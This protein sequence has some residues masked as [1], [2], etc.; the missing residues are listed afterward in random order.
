MRGAWF[1][2]VVVLSSGC[3]TGEKSAVVP[4]EGAI[5]GVELVRAPNAL[6][7]L[8]WQCNEL[9]L[10]VDCAPVGPRPP[11][12][13]L[14]IGFDI[15]I[16]VR[17]PNVTIQIPMI[18]A[19]TGLT[20]FDS[21]NLGSICVT[22]CDPE[23]ERCEAESNAEGAC[24]G[25]QGAPGPEDLA[26]TVPDLIELAIGQDDGTYENHQWRI[27]RA[28]DTTRVTLGY[29]L[30]PSVALP[31]AEVAFEAALDD[32]L[33]GGEPELLVPFSAEGALFF[34]VPQIGRQAFGF[35]PFT[36]QWVLELPKKKK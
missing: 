36:D 35:G 6:Q 33:N 22:L 32:L 13:D 29:E 8:A 18:E 19:L 24:E 26:P 7:V 5:V 12:E 10:G 21:A 27:L 11:D 31:L 14:L 16:D 15:D 1:V 4:P 17:N 3:D 9:G 28:G 23:D 34:E 20:V 2:G 30:S 25:G